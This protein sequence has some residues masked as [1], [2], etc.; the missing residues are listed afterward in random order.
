VVGG[1]RQREVDAAFFARTTVKSN[2]LGNL[3][4][5]DASKAHPRSPRLDFAGAC[6]VV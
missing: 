2:F 6:R 5:G 1:V 3:G 4:Y